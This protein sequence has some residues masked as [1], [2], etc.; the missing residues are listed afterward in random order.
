VVIS[1]AIKSLDKQNLGVAQKKVGDK[2]CE[3]AMLS[4]LFYT[5]TVDST[6]S[7][8][9]KSNVA[10][11]TSSMRA[12]PNHSP[13]GEQGPDHP[14]DQHDAGLELPKSGDLPV[15]QRAIGSPRLVGLDEEFYY[16]VA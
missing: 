8:E 9:S 14:P 16:V 13:T 10:Y 5:R 3:F 6:P 11:S 7:G 1:T 2:N 4:Q 12:Q 15:R